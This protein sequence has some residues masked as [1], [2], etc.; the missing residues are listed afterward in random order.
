MAKKFVVTGLAMVTFGFGFVIQS[1]A[2]TETVEPYRAPA[3]TY[4]YAP[5]RP[6]FYAPPVSFGIAFGPGYGYYGPRFRWYGPRRFYGRYGYW[7][8]H[9]HH[10][11]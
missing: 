5:P 8:F 2:G 1:N 7:R 6:V 4:N 10:W 3:P 11:H 9:P